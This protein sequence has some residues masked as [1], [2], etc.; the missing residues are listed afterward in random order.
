MA[1]S[2]DAIRVQSGWLLDKSPSSQDKTPLLPSSSSLF[3]LPLSLFTF[4]TQRE[5]RER[6][7]QIKAGKKGQADP[8]PSQ[9]SCGISSRVHTRAP[10]KAKES[11]CQSDASRQEVAGCVK[12]KNT[13]QEKERKKETVKPAS[14][15]CLCSTRAVSL[16]CAVKGNAV[17][18]LKP[19]S[20]ERKELLYWEWEIEAARVLAWRSIMEEASSSSGHPRHR[21]PPPPPHHVLGYGGFHAAMA[22]PTNSMPPA[23]FFEQDGGG[24]AYF[25]ELEEALMHQVATLSSGGRR[26][27]HSH[28]HSQQQTATA[29]STAQPHHHHH[30]HGHNHAMPFP[31][32]VADT[33]TAAAAEAAARPPPTLDIFPSWPLAL[34]HHHHTPKEGSNVT[35]DSTDSESSSKNNINMDSSDHHHHQQQQGMAGLVTVAAQFHQISQQQHHQQQ[36]MA[37]SSTHSDRTGKALDPKTTRRLAQ[38]REAA[39]KSRLRKKA[40]IQQL[41]SGKLKLAQ[42]E[43]D[44]QR[45]RSQGLLV[46]GA[47]SGNSSP[48]AA[49]FDV[50]YNRWLDDDSR[51]MI[52]LRG[53]L[54]AHLPDGDLRAII[55][56]T[57]THYDELFR[58][59]SAAAR[60]DVFH[61]ITG[62]WATPAERCFL[63]MGGFRPSDLLKTLAPQLDPLTEQQMVGICSLEQSLQQ[64]EEALT[65]GLEQLH[66]SLAVTVAGSG[67]LSDDT[68]MGSFMGDMA[69]ALGK[70]ANLEGFVIQ[71]DNLRQQTLHQM[72]R[73]LTVRQAARC[74]LAI[75]E[76]HNRLRALSSLWA[77][78]PREILMTDEGNCGEL[79][80]AAHPSESQYS[81]F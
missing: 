16:F 27:S 12:S 39:R 3:L 68:N 69:V 22:V 50:E 48:G 20:Q 7:K 35:A 57:L 36:K 76:Y 67:S 19:S 70:L 25:G 53:G 65:Q 1:V 78:R 11:V 79:S 54:H 42:L 66:Q 2:S 14:C 51:R 10:H 47:P 33:A 17:H 26:I 21:G 46:G 56:D 13:G 80:I 43:Q 32:T 77:S 23:T 72:H 74:F 4:H 71:A 58:L 6:P 64:A 52:E 61:L 28:S 81:A 34:H 18:A 45:A 41:E 75:G 5:E 9:L 59:K 37:T 15:C 62:M 30:H 8:R 55:D 44:L 63:W 49:M 31:S 24:G 38:N 60:A 29:T 40:Y 73:I